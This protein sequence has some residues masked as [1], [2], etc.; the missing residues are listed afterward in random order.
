[1]D[2]IPRSAFGD[3]PAKAIFGFAWRHLRL[4]SLPGGFL[5]YWYCRQ[6]QLYYAASKVFAVQN[7]VTAEEIDLPSHIALLPTE[8]TCLPDF[9]LKFLV[10]H[11]KWFHA[12]EAALARLETQK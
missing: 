4:S 5:G 12:Y 2:Y 7:D 8:I 11:E 1:M 6:K 9:H 3:R 10:P